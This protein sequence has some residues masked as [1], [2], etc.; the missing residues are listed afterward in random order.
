MYTSLYTFLNQRLSREKADPLYIQLDKAVREAVE[1][2]ELKP[3]SCLPSE[4]N[5]MQHLDVSRKTVRHAFELLRSDNIID[6][7]QGM[8]TFVRRKLNYALKDSKGF[9]EVVSRLGGVPNTRWL[10]KKEAIAEGEVADQLQIP[11]GSSVWQL[12]RLRFI[13][14]QP[15]SIENSY[16]RY[17]AIQNIEDIGTSLY[18]YFQT[19]GISTKNKTSYIR[20]DLPSEEVMRLIQVKDNCPILIIRQRML[21]GVTNE[22]LEYSVN[23]C[24][25]DV[26]EFVVD[27]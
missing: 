9:S 22:P 23:Y 6:S 17:E 8:G 11:S 27:D 26:Y 24:R 13:D 1:Q 2:G 12:K 25:S 15:V 18:D 4:R 14:G 19:R 20:A 10:E 16:V 21:S 5:L 3:N 7:A